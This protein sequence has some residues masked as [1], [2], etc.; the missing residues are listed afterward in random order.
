M[1]IG[2]ISFLLSCCCVNDALLRCTVCVLIIEIICVKEITNGYKGF[3]V[4][5]FA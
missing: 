2:H 3:T 1:V 4:S 5:C